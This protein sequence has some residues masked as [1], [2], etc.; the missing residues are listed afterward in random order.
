M[1]ADFLVAF[2][3][4]FIPAA[5][6]AFACGLAAI[7]VWSRLVNLA[8][9]DNTEISYITP[10]AEEADDDVTGF[11]ESSYGYQVSSWDVAANPEHDDVAM[12]IIRPPQ[13]KIPVA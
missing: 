13:K 5:A 10:G 9:D 6:I 3:S 1:T 12:S 11:F 4:A 7:A 8:G 2:A